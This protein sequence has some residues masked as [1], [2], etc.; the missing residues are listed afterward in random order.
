MSGIAGGPNIVRD[1]IV[2]WLDGADNQ[3]F[4]GEPTTNI[5]PRSSTTLAF[6]SAYDGANYG[7]GSGTNIQQQFDDNLRP[8]SQSRVT[9]VSRINSGVSQRTYVSVGLHSSL[10]SVRIV[11]FWYYGTFGTNIRPYNNDGSANLSYLDSNGNWV[12]STTAV[13][14]PVVENQ[15]QRISLRITNN[16]GSA[17]TGWSWL[18]LHNNSHPVSLS[19]T[20]YWAFSEFMYEDAVNPSYFYTSGTRGTTFA[21]GGGWADMSGNS[22][23]GE[24]INNPTFNSSNLGSL[25]FD[26]IDDY[27]SIPSFTFTPYCLDFWLYNNNLVPNNDSAI[28]GPSTYQ[29]LIHYPG[30]MI[31][32]GGWTSAATNEALHIWSF[33]GGSRLTYTR[34]AVPV[35]NHHWVFNWNG[36]HYDIWVDGQKQTVYASTNGHALLGSLTNTIRLGY[37]GNTYYFHGKIYS[38]KM[39]GSQRT[40]T[41]VLQNYNATKYRFGL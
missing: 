36:T 21:T 6:T 39:Y 34:T 14:I 11:S 31:S 3:S 20:E 4:R 12:G 8:E 9:R 22:N 10:N 2:L 40:D 27:I 25:V 13:N 26:A 24:L 18:I 41:Q 33:T 35:G 32:L 30:G 28:G 15:W 23:H 16:G 29:T 37:D 17:G 5:F 38:F 1:G 19:N 7:F